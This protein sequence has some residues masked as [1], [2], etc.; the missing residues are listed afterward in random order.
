MREQVLSPCLIDHAV[1]TLGGI[2]GKPTME[3][4]KQTR[5]FIRKAV[6]TQ[7]LT[8]TW[9]LHITPFNSTIIMLMLTKRMLPINKKYKLRS[10]VNVKPYSDSEVLRQKMNEWLKRFLHMAC[11]IYEAEHL[12]KL[13]TVLLRL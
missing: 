2:I 12:T 6:T 1:M 11:Y 7:P 8:S 9:I 13:S 3:N 5:N 4:M 10:K